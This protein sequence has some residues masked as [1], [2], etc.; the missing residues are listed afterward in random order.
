VLA[1]LSLLNKT[2][3]LERAN[4]YRVGGLKG[5]LQG[6]NRQTSSWGRKSN[7]RGTEAQ[8]REAK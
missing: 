4:A 5:R 3:L 1:E 7:H 6:L 8:R 2:K